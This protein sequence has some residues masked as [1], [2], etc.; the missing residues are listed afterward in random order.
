MANRLYL[1]SL[2]VSD[3]NSSRG[4]AYDWYV[5]ATNYKVAKV[6][7]LTRI[8]VVPVKKHLDCWGAAI[9]MLGIS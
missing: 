6:I 8:R 1:E 5:V 2:I 3:F 4:P 9:Y 7:A